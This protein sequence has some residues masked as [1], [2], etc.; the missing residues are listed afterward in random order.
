MLC[1][2]LSP[3]GAPANPA[4]AREG[5]GGGGIAGPAAPRMRPSVCSLAVGSLLTWCL[6]PPPTYACRLPPPCPRLRHHAADRHQQGAVRGAGCRGPPRGQF[7]PHLPRRHQGQDG[8][9]GERGAG[10]GGGRSHR[11]NHHHRHSDQHPSHPLKA[12]TAA[13]GRHPIPTLTGWQAPLT[14][15]GT[16]HDHIQHD[17]PDPLLRFTDA[18]STY[19]PL[20]HMA[21]AAGS[22]AW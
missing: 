18:L 12:R 21:M 17:T 22:R 1:G 3:A 14:S 8:C 10:A 6:P 7:H 19:R 5:W 16:R 2:P 13:P 20:L 9:A 11:R 15:L 4:Q